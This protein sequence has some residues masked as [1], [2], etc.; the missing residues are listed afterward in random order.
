[1]SDV[2]IDKQ[3]F[4][5]IEM[6]RKKEYCSLDY[7]A[8]TMEVSTR[9]IRNYIKQLN[10]D[11]NGIGALVNE[12]GKGYRLV[13]EDEQ[14]FE[15]LMGKINA[16]KNFQDSPQ[17]RIA[18]IIDRLINSDKTNTLDELAFDMNLGRTTLV[19]E[20]KKAAVALKSYNLAI[21]GKPNT[22][23]YLSG[24]EHD[25]RFFIL[26]NVYDFLYSL[27]PLDEDI[28]E[29]IIRIANQYDL[30]ST[31]QNRLMQFAIVMLDRLLKNHPLMEI[32]EK[33]HKLLNTKDYQIALEV[34][35]V[36][37]SHL[38]ITIPKPEILFITLPIAGRRT[39]TN[40]RTMVDITITED[41]KGLLN[42]IFEQIGLDKGIIHENQIFFKDL[43]YH[44][45]F[46][47]NRL[48]FGLRLK[49]PLLPDV[50]EKYPVAFKMAAIAGQVIENE[51]N[52]EVTE[53]EL[54]YIAFYFGVFITQN[55]VKV[56]RLHRVAVVCGTG[57]GT[58]KLVA[59]QL[60]RVL[61][62]NTEIDLFSEK[63][64]TKE[65]LAD[66]D[67]VFSTVKLGFETDSPLIMIN[68][69]FDE[70]MVS[71]KIE[72]VT[73]LKKF[74]LKNAR[75]HHSIVKLLTNEE[76]YFILDSR[77]SYHENVNDMIDALVMKGYFDEGFKERLKVRAE[78]GSMVFDQYIALPHT[79]NHKSNKIELALG[80]FPEKITVDGKEIKLVFLLGIPEQTDN[81]ANLLVKIYEEIIQIA[82]DK[83]LINQLASTNSYEDLSI[84]LEQASRS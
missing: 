52:L 19:N 16:E 38:P 48:M 13:I 58:A 8:E 65:R 28:K 15:E 62:Q 55:E 22:G 23:M 73:Y 69:I 35:E 56:N 71:R 6:T 53:D 32:Q 41:I 36:I 78:K 12:K 63:E 17:R 76:K 49:N 42:L 81:D 43:Q 10:S 9:T 70:N 72:K 25:L 79:V 39:P 57:R 60:Q 33:H 11:L 46:M 7:L 82:A 50:K 26:D 74:K 59:I 47:L 45:T 30:D 44:L 21:R 54:G 83:Q 34:I 37:E 80:V 51:Y 1:M 4:R 18:F 84:Y 77:K 75:N 2:S 5:L 20:L 27:Y 31:T 24:N 68:E 40:N 29:A 64:V 3:L 66:Y 14:K 67:I 61:N